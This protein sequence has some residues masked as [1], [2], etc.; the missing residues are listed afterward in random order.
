MPRLLPSLTLQA[1]TRLEL[2]V[3]QLP[4]LTPVVA[5]SVVLQ[6]QPPLRPEI[7]RH[8]R[9]PVRALVT[10]ACSPVGAGECCSAGQATG[11]EP[12]SIQQLRH[13]SI[14]RIRQGMMNWHSS[15]HNQHCGGPSSAS[16]RRLGPAPPSSP[17]TSREQPHARTSAR[18]PP[19]HLRGCATPCWTPVCRCSGAPPHSPSY[20]LLWRR[21]GAA[22]S[23]TAW[24]GSPRTPCAARRAVR[25]PRSASS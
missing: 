25:A 17:P 11:G 16:A 8:P 19:P 21:R 9:P 7:H 6:M 20:H 12:Q 22:A 2:P 13:V 18:S 5:Q 4:S 15:R 1:G 14:V 10:R 23:C 24:R 3:A